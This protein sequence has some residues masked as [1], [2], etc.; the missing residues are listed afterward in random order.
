MR[1]RKRLVAAILI[2][3]VFGCG[4]LERWYLNARAISDDAWNEMQEVQR[5]LEVGMTR[6]EVEQRVQHAL[7]HYHC[8]YGGHSDFSVDIYL[9]GTSDATLAGKLYLR[10]DRVEDTVEL[11]YIAEFDDMDEFQDAISRCSAVP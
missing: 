5:S 9:F 8:D 2:F 3:L 1:A 6:Q 4:I 10:F 7:T 11:V